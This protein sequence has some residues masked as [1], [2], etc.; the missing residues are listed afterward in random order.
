LTGLRNRTT[1]FTAQHSTA[2]GIDKVAE[3]NLVATIV[4]GEEVYKG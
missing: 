1:F 2:Q 4:D 3:A